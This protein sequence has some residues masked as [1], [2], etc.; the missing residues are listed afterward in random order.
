MSQNKKDREKLI[1]KYVVRLFIDT[2]NPIGSGFISKQLPMDIS[3]ATIRNIMSELEE[4]GYLRHPHTSAGR[5]PTDKGYR[6]YVNDMVD[7]EE[8]SVQEK[9]ILSSAIR[10]ITH[11]I[12]QIAKGVDDVLFF[13]SKALA[14]ISNEL[15]IILSPRFNLCIFE[16]L[17]LIPIAVGRILIELSLRSGFVKNVILE[18]ES[19]LE[20]GEL[21]KIEQ[22]L[23]ERLSGLT[24]AEIRKT[25]A[26]RLKDLSFTDTQR[27]HFYRVFLSS[28]DQLFNFDDK[29]LLTFAGANNILSK[30]DFSESNDPFAIIRM[31]EEKSRFV[32][33]L[34]E[35]IEGGGVAVTIGGENDIKDMNGC[36]IVKA[37][38]RLGDVTGTVGVIGPKRMPYGKIIPLVRHTA[39]LLDEAL[40]ND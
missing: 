10:E 31:L 30:P 14:D 9:T 15:G 33:L 2:G 4:Q 29:N 40:N 28:S 11:K 21:P 17:N 20:H 36:S 3:A 1:L 35:Q 24:V 27:R 5:V 6:A 32:D 19:N 8:L 26:D 39:N 34:S 25:I 18:V 12:S 38:Y 22:V 13:S 37:N 7:L 16:K 23:N